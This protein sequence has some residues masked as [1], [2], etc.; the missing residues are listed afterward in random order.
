MLYLSLFNQLDVKDWIFT[1][2]VLTA[3]GVCILSG[4]IFCA[5][6]AYIPLTLKSSEKI[7]GSNTLLSDLIDKLT[8]KRLSLL[9][10][11]FSIPARLFF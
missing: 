11:P 7:D 3:V 8:L 1:Q 10:Q 5:A 4:M 6:S 2:V 9:I